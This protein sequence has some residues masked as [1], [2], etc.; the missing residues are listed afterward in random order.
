M[1]QAGRQLRE[2]GC[3]PPGSRKGERDQG[4]LSHFKVDTEV[5]CNYIPG[6]LVKEAPVTEEEGENEGGH[7]RLTYRLS[8]H[9]LD[10]KGTADFSVFL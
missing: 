2:V 9:L 3:H 5:I 7:W 1:T 4:P 8:Q 6:H 10:S